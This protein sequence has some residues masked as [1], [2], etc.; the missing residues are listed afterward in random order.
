MGALAR[1]G[2]F[3]LHLAL[4]AEGRSSVGTHVTRAGAVLIAAAL[5]ALGVGLIQAL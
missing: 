1:S 3:F 4:G 2:G 5:I